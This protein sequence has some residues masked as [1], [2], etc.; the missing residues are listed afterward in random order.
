M[1]QR[2]QLHHSLVASEGPYNALTIICVLTYLN[3]VTN[4][5]TTRVQLSEAMDF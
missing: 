5:Q 3:L 1:Q 2:N 4:K